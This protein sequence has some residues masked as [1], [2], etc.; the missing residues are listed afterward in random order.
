MKNESVETIGSAGEDCPQCDNLGRL[1][2]HGDPCEWCY[3]MP[4]SKFNQ[5]TESNGSTVGSDGSL[6]GYIREHKND[7]EQVPKHVR[8]HYVEYGQ[9]DQHTTDQSDGASGSEGVDS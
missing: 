1:M 3:R 9:N 7:A 8:D 5:N 6:R 4:N 2:P